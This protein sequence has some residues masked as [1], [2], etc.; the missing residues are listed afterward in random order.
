[1][2]DG[3]YSH[4]SLG[5]S[6]F[7]EEES[8]PYLFS[9]RVAWEPRLHIIPRPSGQ[10]RAASTAPHSNASLDGSAWQMYTRENRLNLHLLEHPYWVNKSP[11]IGFSSRERFNAFSTT[12]PRMTP[13]RPAWDHSFV[14][15]HVRL[16]RSRIRCRMPIFHFNMLLSH[17]KS[18]VAHRCICTKVERWLTISIVDLAAHS[19]DKLLFSLYHNILPAS[20]TQKLDGT[21][22]RQVGML[23]EC[24]LVLL[25]CD[26][27]A[28][29]VG[30]IDRMA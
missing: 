2:S 29:G 24:H 26:E 6:V 8:D 5:G 10:M 28:N 4:L 1:M 16:L 17:N 30:P 13:R 14:V 12:S 25:S 9:R 15:A 21:P 20:L 22:A 18:S 19:V 7:T 3:C 27:V 11:G 23:L